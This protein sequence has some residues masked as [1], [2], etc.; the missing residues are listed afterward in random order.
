M[1]GAAD[2]A[3]SGVDVC[4]APAGPGV[5]ALA[6]RCPARTVG[7]TFCPNSSE[8]AAA[9]LGGVDPQ[10]FTPFLLA[11]QSAVPLSEAEIRFFAR[12]P[13]TLAKLGPQGTADCTCSC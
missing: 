10:G 9:V 13:A 4:A 12:W 1:C 7:P 5:D 11:C 6:V 8:V 3:P 2:A